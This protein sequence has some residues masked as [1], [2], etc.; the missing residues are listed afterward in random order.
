MAK[1]TTTLFG[2]L[3]IIP[4]Q[5]EAPISETLEFYTDV[6]LAS[7]GTEKRLQLRTFPRQIFEYNIP[8]QA[9][10]I[11]E[12]F[13]A[14]YGAVRK[15]WA[16]PIWTEGQLV[17]DVVTGATSI[18]CDTTLYDLRANSLAMLYS[19]SGDWQIVEISTL[20]SISVTVSNTLQSMVSA[21]L[22]PVRVGWIVGSPTRKINGYNGSLSVVFQVDDNGA[23]TETVPSQ[24]LSNDIYYNAGLLMDGS[25][26]RSIQ[27]ETETIDFELGKV[28]YRTT[29]TNSR[30]AGVHTFI[31]EGASEVRA[32]KRF[33]ARCAGKFRSFWM[34]SF[35]SNLRVANTGTIGSTLTINRDGFAD[36]TF[37]K[38]IT[39]LDAQGARYNRVVSNPVNV[40]GNLLSLT[41]STPLN[42]QAKNVSLVSYLGLYRFDSDK[43]E[44]NWIGNNVA[45]VSIPIVEITP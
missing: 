3:A 11:Q 35:E 16:I 12:S 28:E 37:R 38:N 42:I 31:L 30:S 40:I 25:T 21:Y 23:I 4:F 44:I 19:A 17:G 2:E 14:L 24:Y 7:D 5:A 36:Y 1:I 8:L 26:S 27:M 13:N 34:P 6:M 39:I 18:S 10:Q 20:D 29:W 41:L 33:V 15:K 45:S 22:I 43:V 9:T 32:F